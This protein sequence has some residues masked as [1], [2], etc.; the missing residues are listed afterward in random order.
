MILD[1]FGL[2]VDSPIYEYYMPK[3]SKIPLYQSLFYL[4]NSNS[5]KHVLTADCYV[6]SESHCLKFSA[7]ALQKYWKRSMY[8]YLKRIL[9]FRV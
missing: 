9:L 5:C 4:I 8:M 6:H 1:W 3:F 7:S 2:Q